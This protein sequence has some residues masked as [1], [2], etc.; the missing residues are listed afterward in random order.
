[1]KHAVGIDVG[2]T[3]TRVALINEDYKII[4][5]KQ[6]PTDPENPQKT[7]DDIKA[8]IDSFGYQV[9][10]IGISCPGPLDLIHGVILTPPNLLGWHFFEL[11]KCL[12]EKTGVS[13]YLENDAN[14]ACLAEA[15]IGAGKGKDY[16][17]FLTISTGVG[18]GFCIK[19][20]I[21]RGAKGFAQEV[22]NSILWKN[23]PSQ[24]DL[25]KGSIEAIASGTAITKRAIE[26]GLSAAHAGE[27]NQ[28]AQEGN[29]CAAEIME[30][31]YEY[32]SSFL[33][34]LYGVL[35]PDI[36]VL[37]GS[38][39]LKIPGFIEEIEKRVKTKVYDTLKENVHVV[40]AV[41]GEDCGLIGAACL[42]FQSIES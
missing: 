26:A 27:V 5:R 42:V 24:G 3:N 30:D 21:F 10:G 8:V 19:E 38:V 41:L 4:E 17:Q 16:V 32:L 33:G 1:M 37:G 6:F 13:V 39:A 20:N 25:K 40:P 28:M 9:E 15:V 35:D 18:A 7:L 31:A 12:Q 11:T 23:G 29:E 2:G 14:L 22:A 36:F 34:I